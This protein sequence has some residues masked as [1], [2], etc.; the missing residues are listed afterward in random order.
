MPHICSDSACCP[1]RVL[2][3]PFG[4]A[5]FRTSVHRTRI[6]DN[7]WASAFST[8]PGPRSRPERMRP[9][10]R[11]RWIYSH[12]IEDDDH[13]ESPSQSCMWSSG[14][15]MSAVYTLIVKTSFARSIRIGPPPTSDFPIYPIALCGPWQTA[16]ALWHSLL[17]IVTVSLPQISCG[18]SPSCSLSP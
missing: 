14:A 10:K 11:N 1:L 8:S 7:F 18:L 5:T 13:R 12:C 6:I 16:K 17:Y 2:M 3:F 4:A 15:L 9:R